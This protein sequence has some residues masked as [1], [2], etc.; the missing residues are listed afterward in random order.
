MHSETTLPRDVRRGQLL[1][2]TGVR[3][4]EAVAAAPEEPVV[5]PG[6]GKRA[7]LGGSGTN[8]RLVAA[9]LASRGGGCQRNLRRLYRKL[10]AVRGSPA[11]Q[12]TQG[13]LWVGSGGKG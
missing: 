3:V 11:L 7:G 4:S 8:L 1:Q 10:S 13:A 12:H 2:V 6:E 9:A 5:T